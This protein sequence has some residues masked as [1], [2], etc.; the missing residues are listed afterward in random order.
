MMPRTTGGLV[1]AGLILVVALFCSP[2][3]LAQQEEERCC[4]VV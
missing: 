4:E 2:Q 3:P 1:G